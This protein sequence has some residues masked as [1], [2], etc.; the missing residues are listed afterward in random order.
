[1]ASNPTLETIMT[2][3]SVRDFKPD[4]VDDEK[5]RIILGAAV[6][7][8]S[9]GNSQPWEFVVI[10]DSDTKRRVEEV[11]RGR[12]HAAMDSRI[13]A[14]PPKERRLY[15]GSTRLVDRTSNVPVIILACVDLNRASKSEEARYAS[16][17][18]AVENLML[19]AWSMGLGACITTHGSSAARG[20]AEV[21]AILGI[22]GNIK[23]AALLYVGYPARQHHPPT[24][25]GIEKVIHNDAW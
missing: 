12:W 7:A 4:P 15:E 1:M 9:S 21:K 10:R 25:L 24:R 2:M 22:P 16:I 19:A 18:P 13:A 17:Y 3:R 6:M 14:M 5:L 8:P 11:I 20:E 23:I